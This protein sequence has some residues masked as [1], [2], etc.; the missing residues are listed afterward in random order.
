MA[1]L[2]KK[3]CQSLLLSKI[4]VT[5]YRELIVKVPNSKNIDPKSFIR[6]QWVNSDLLTHLEEL[7]P[8]DRVLVDLLLV[9]NC[10]SFETFL[11]LRELRSHLRQLLAFNLGT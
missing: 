6:A 8:E 10:E 4:R 2:G 5:T 9:L 11:E 1:R 7:I 3:F